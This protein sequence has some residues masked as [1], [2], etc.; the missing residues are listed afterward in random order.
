MQ[1][2]LT[3]SRDHASFCAV[4]RSA[5]RRIAGKETDSQFFSE[6]EP[7]SRLATHPHGV[8]QQAAILE[9]TWV[10][11]WCSQLTTDQSVGVS[12]RRTGPTV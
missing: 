7:H 9:G 1:S 2:T 6:K 11:T 5:A 10:L 4:F 3:E 8:R 12:M